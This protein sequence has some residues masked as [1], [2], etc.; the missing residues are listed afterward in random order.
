MLAAGGR[1][2]PSDTQRRST[3]ACFCVPGPPNFGLSR[4]GEHSPQSDARHGP[5]PRQRTRFG[6]VQPPRAVFSRVDTS[7]RAAGAHAE[8]AAACVDGSAA[9]T[10]PLAISPP[11]LTLAATP[12]P[13]SPQPVGT[14]RRTTV[15]VQPSRTAASAPRTV[16]QLRRAARARSAR[17]VSQ[18]DSAATLRTSSR[19]NPPT[20]RS[21]ASSS[22]VRSPS[23]ISSAA[24]SHEAKRASGCCAHVHAPSGS[25]S[26]SLAA[27]RRHFEQFSHCTQPQT[28]SHRLDDT[29]RVTSSPRKHATSGRDRNCLPSLE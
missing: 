4:H 14:A 8:A 27:S 10:A 26:M 7:L 16:S 19:S 12:P 11:S 22:L 9:C 23:S 21:I 24:T 25:A 6:P 13:P 18:L 1:A 2:G 17:R 20:A 15:A 3:H 5:Q 28:S 29:T